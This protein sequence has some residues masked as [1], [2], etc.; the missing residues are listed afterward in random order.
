MPFTSLACSSAYPG[1]N[2]RGGSIQVDGG[3]DQ[4]RVSVVS[5]ASMA[6]MG[7]WGAAATSTTL[8]ACCARIHVP[9]G[10][11]AQRAAAWSRDGV[12]S[13][14]V[15]AGRAGR[16]LTHALLGRLLIRMVMVVTGSR[17]T[18]RTSPSVALTLSPKSP[19][20]GT[21]ADR[22]PLERLLLSGMVPRGLDTEVSDRWQRLRRFVLSPATLL[23][24]IVCAFA[25]LKSD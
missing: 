5:M 1:K 7:G 11:P 6:S 2:D 21:V 13:G 12:G 25:R 17:T 24:A 3:G 22:E 20:S 19:S 23:R 15:H 4:W 14:R 18:R 16:A 8:F 9:R 10:A